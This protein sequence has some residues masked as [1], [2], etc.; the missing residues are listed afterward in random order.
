LEKERP[1]FCGAKGRTIS[2]NSMG[3]RGG[4]CEPNLRGEKMEDTVDQN[5]TYRRGTTVAEIKRFT[6]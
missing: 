2:K 4:G 5:P 3:A 6:V 1:A